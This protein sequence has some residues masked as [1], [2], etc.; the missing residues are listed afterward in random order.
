MLLYDDVI[1]TL[2]LY[3]GKTYFEGTAPNFS[4]VI[5]LNEFYS[6]GFCYSKVTIQK[7]MKPLGVCTLQTRNKNTDYAIFTDWLSQFTW[8]FA[9]TFYWKFRLLTNKLLLVCWSVIFYLKNQRS[10]M[11]WREILTTNG[12]W[13]NYVTWK[14]SC[15]LRVFYR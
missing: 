13:P 9:G 12:S 5:Q 8:N 1:M 6:V 2:W 7:K 15:K 3:K 11:H 10:H 14:N 4:H